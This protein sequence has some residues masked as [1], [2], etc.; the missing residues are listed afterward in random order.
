MKRRDGKRHRSRPV[1]NRGGAWRQ[2]RHASLRMSQ[3]GVRP[4]EVDLVH[5]FGESARARGDCRRHW[6]PRKTAAEAVAG[7]ETIGAVERALRLVV[8]AASGGSVVTT[9]LHSF[10]GRRRSAPGRPAAESRDASSRRHRRHHKRS[11]A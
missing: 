4:G 3:R 11:R 6:L 1:G 9:Y 2:T 5:T 10:R 8:V 7:G